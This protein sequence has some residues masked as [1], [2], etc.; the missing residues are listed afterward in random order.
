VT[1]H[2]EDPDRER[3]ESVRR[4]AAQAPGL[5]LL[6]L[7]GSRARGDA[8]GE[9]DWDF[10][11]AGDLDVDQLRVDVARALGTD[12]VDLVDLARAGALLRYRV[13]RD[14]RAILEQKP[15]MFDDFR[16]RSASFWC[17]VAPIVTAAYDG[18]LDGL[19]R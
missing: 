11:F 6:V 13:A 1:A 18:V 10:A 12:A 2:A 16:T 4:I 3:L 19:D 14:G 15:G 9:A 5:A 7:F 8:R 17:D